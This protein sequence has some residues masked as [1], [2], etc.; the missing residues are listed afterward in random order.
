MFVHGVDIEQARARPGLLVRRGHAKRLPTF[1][2]A[3]PQDGHQD[4]Q[5]ALE[6]EQ[7]KVLKALRA[8]S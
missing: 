5:F 2:A 6:A 4:Q 7:E 1:S 3:T 8:C